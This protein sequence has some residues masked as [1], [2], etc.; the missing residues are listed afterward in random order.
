MSDVALAQPSTDTSSEATI[1]SPKISIKN[2]PQP[3]NI[4]EYIDK[5]LEEIGDIYKYNQEQFITYINNKLGFNFRFDSKMAR[6][7]FRLSQATNEG[8]DGS[9]VEF[10]KRAVFEILHPINKS[11]LA[12][13]YAELV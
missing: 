7:L 3:F 5:C 11:L 13:L 2:I 12:E 8:I 6:Y 9:K 1:S 10:G 4:D